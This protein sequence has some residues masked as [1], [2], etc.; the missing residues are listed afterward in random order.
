ML[1]VISF[2]ATV[3]CYLRK[4][5][6]RITD[7]NSTLSITKIIKNKPVNPSILEDLQAC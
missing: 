3:A 4:N 1:S 6:I 5:I 7:K 2:G